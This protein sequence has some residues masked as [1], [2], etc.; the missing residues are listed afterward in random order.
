MMAV[1]SKTLYLHHVELFQQ[2]VSLWV[3]EEV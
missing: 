3:M 2:Q 1:V